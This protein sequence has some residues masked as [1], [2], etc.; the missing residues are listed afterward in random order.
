MKTYGYF[1]STISKVWLHNNEIL[2]TD[3][4][5]MYAKDLPFFPESS[6]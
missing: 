1:K 2:K 6:L 5:A 4:A 3:Q